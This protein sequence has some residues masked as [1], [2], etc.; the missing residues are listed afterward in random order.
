MTMFI[1]CKARLH[2]VPLFNRTHSLAS[3]SAFVNGITF[4]SCLTFH[5]Y[6]PSQL[7]QSNIVHA[8]TQASSLN[9]WATNKALRNS[10]LWSFMIIFLSSIKEINVSTFKLTCKLQHLLAV[11]SALATWELRQLSTICSR[12]T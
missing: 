10:V 5:P 2:L 11:N 7:D 9:T 6:L 12:I 4:R 8:S 3:F 1:N